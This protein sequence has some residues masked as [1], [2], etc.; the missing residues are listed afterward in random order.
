MKYFSMQYIS[1]ARLPSVGQA[2]LQIKTK[3]LSA[4][5]LDPLPSAEFIQV[6]TSLLTKAPKD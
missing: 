2:G 6:V 5:Q 4:V 1:V 3:Q